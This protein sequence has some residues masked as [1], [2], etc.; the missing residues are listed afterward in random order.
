MEQLV[1]I[2][3]QWI[4]LERLHVVESPLGRGPVD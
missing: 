2:T 1:V 3:L 4:A